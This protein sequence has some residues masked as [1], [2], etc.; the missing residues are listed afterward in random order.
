MPKGLAGVA[1]P[2]GVTKPVAPALVARWIGVGRSEIGNEH[3]GV[4]INLGLEN[5]EPGIVAAYNKHA[6][7][8]AAM[9][10]TDRHVAGDRRGAR[11]RG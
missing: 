9:L 6:R 11:P 3:Y 7:R 8:G 10:N 1:G 5:T 4:I 2:V